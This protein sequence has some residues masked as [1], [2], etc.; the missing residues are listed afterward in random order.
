M[1]RHARC[2]TRPGAG[3]CTHPPE[4]ARPLCPRTCR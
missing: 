2:A 3:W 1:R 4:A